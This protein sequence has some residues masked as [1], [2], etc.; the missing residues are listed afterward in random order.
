MSTLHNQDRRIDLL[1]GALE[2]VV[3]T[4]TTVSPHAA[5]MLKEFHAQ[6][7]AKAQQAETE[8]QLDLL[9]GRGPLATAA[10]NL[11]E[12]YMNLGREQ[13]LEIPSDMLPGTV[14]DPAYLPRLNNQLTHFFGEREV[15][16]ARDGWVSWKIW[17]KTLLVAQPE[18][19]DA[20]FDDADLADG[21]YHTLSE[22]GLAY[23]LNGVRD[24]QGRQD[25]QQGLESN[26]RYLLLRIPSDD[27]RTFLL[28]TR[29][30]AAFLTRVPIE[31]TWVVH[32]FSQYISEA[33]FNSALQNFLKAKLPAGFGEPIDA[34]ELA[35]SLRRPMDGLPK[36]KL[37][38]EDWVEL[39][40]QANHDTGY[41]FAVSE[42]D[43]LIKLNTRLLALTFEL[44]K[45]LI[46]E[47]K[48][49]IHVNQHAGIEPRRWHEFT[50]R[51]QVALANA[52]S[53][54]VQRFLKLAR[55]KLGL[56]DPSEKP[57]AVKKL[58]A[59]NPVAKKRPLPIKAQP[60]PV[61]KPVK[62]AA[63]KKA[64]PAKK[65]VK[66]TAKKTSRR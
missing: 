12:V 13:P 16:H 56:P 42:Q 26:T 40:K 47:G 54:L 21:M 7:A 64:A 28:A 63:A 18:L 27:N 8:K 29:F 30:G 60:L 34:S 52:C 24:A 44:D 55:A 58:E 35:R 45:G 49:N 11:N 66:K 5:N 9:T 57:A 61:T 51:T 65:A 17:D 33:A 46:G 50:P 39:F 20:M 53:Q 48:F 23:E 2:V 59:T 10:R 6:Y 32:S 19:T 22:M 14:A 37:T 38:L 4:L 62:K 3:S 25:F 1:E 41:R 15:S 36:N 31:G 43:G